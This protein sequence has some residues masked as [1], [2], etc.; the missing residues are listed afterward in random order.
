METVQVP[1][2]C[3][4]PPDRGRTHLEE[5]S[6]GLLIDTE[7]SM[8]REVLHEEG[9]ASYQTDRTKKRAC[10]PD[11]DECI[12]NERTVPGRTMT[13]NMLRGVSHEDT[14]S[15]QVALSCPVQD[16]GGILPVVPRGFTEV[17]QAWLTSLPSLLSSTLVP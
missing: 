11:G 7:M 4:E 8:H 16:T 10:T 12:L 1:L 6:P 3:Q 17:I 9:H 15:Q 13:V 2:C 5:K 14:V